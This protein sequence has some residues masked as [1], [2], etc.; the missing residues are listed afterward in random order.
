MKLKLKKLIIKNEESI[1]SH[2]KFSRIFVEIPNQPIRLRQTVKAVK[3]QIVPTILKKMRLKSNTPVK[4]DRYAGCV[5]GCSP[6]FI[7]QHKPGEEVRMV[8]VDVK[9]S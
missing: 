8:F 7:V 9:I 1:S 2:W 5:C 6:G 4:F 3:T